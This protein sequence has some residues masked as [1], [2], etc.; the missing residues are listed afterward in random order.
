MTQWHLFGPPVSRSLDTGPDRVEPALRDLGDRPRLHVDNVV[1]RV[2]QQVGSAIDPGTH[3]S[4]R[5]GRLK[6][7]HL[8]S[9]MRAGCTSTT[10]ADLTLREANIPASSTVPLAH[11]SFMVLS[12]RI[13]RPGFALILE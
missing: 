11:S 6:A 5:S 7:G 3:D 8:T 1:A 12:Y 13:R 4:H 10:S 2:G 9:A